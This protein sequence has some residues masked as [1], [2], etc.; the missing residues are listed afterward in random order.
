MWTARQ[1][2]PLARFL[3]I[4]VTVV[5]VGPIEAAWASSKQVLVLYSTSRDAHISVTVTVSCRDYSNRVW[6]TT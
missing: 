5:V 2:V 6:E 1:H 3:L 4:A